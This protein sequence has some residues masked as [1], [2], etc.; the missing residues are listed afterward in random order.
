MKE[1]TTPDDAAAEAGLA[2]LASLLEAMSP[3]Q[4]QRLLEK[5]DAQMAEIGAQID[6]AQLKLRAVRLETRAKVA[7]LNARMS[8]L[9]RQ[10]LELA[11]RAP[12]TRIG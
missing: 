3:E 2:Q 12:G 10:R 4:A 8:H 1:T 7:P 11:R 6:E 5:T 9:N